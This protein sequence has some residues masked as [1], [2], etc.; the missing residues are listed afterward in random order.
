[1]SCESKCYETRAF[2]EA[3]QLIRVATANGKYQKD[4]PHPACNGCNEY[5]R[6]LREAA[7]LKPGEVLHVTRNPDGT[8]TRRIGRQG[9]VIPTPGPALPRVRTDEELFAEFNRKFQV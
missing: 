7:N 2:N 9:E 3:G 8:E 1:M 4:Q 6:I 5:E